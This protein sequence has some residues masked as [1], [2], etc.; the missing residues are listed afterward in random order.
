M[1][2]T[3]VTAFVPILIRG[4]ELLSDGNPGDTIAG[5][6][7]VDT[8]VLEETSKPIVESIMPG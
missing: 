7:T 2:Q 5:E 4:A 3:G 6:V 1:T 8:G